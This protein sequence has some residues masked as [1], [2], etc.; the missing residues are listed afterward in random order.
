MGRPAEGQL[1]RY[2]EGGASIE[3]KS[4]HIQ[5]LRPHHYTMARMVA[6]GLQTGEISGLTGFRESHVS[7]IVGTP[8]FQAEVA[9]IR[10]M[11]E[12]DGMDIHKELRT[13]AENAVE[14]LSMNINTQAS[15]EKEK[16]RQQRAAFDVLDRAGFGK[17]ETH[18]SKNLHLH[19]QVKDVRNMTTEELQEDITDLI[20]VE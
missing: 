11:H 6:E 16:D 3:G 20:E 18:I 8:A 9:R 19:A 5:Q 13:L 7:R 15:S 17:T 12:R 4:P 10:G 2:E 14:V 1:I